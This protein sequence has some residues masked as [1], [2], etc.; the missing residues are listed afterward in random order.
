MVCHKRHNTL[1]DNVGSVV[2][3]GLQIGDS[4]VLF[5]AKLPPADLP[6]VYSSKTPFLVVWNFLIFI[7]PLFRFQ[8][9][10]FGGV[11][12]SGLHTIRTSDCVDLSME[13]E[14]GEM[15]LSDTH[16]LRVG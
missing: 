3:V 12:L 5:T 8:N 4:S 16:T 7:Y 11:E 15:P 10:F 9:I 2:G 6:T 13:G 14:R 1:P